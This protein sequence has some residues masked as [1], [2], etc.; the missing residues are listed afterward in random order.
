MV[1]TEGSSTVGFRSTD[2][3]DNLETEKTVDFKID[4]TPPTVTASSSPVPN[5][6]GWNKSDVVVSFSATDALSGIAS[7]D[8]P[9]TLTLEGN[10]Q[11]VVGK[12]TDKAGNQGS[13]S[14]TVSIDKTPPNTTAALDPS[15]PNGENGWYR[16][17]VTVTLNASDNLAGVAKTEYRFNGD[18]W[19]AYASPFVVSREGSN[20]LIFGSTDRADNVETERLATVK[21]DKTPPVI[22]INSPMAKDYTMAVHDD[23]DEECGEDDERDKHD[24]NDDEDNECGG[25]LTISFSA[26][27]SFS[28][29]AW[30]SGYIDGRAVSNGTTVD[31][32][33]LGLGTHTFVVWAKDNAGN[34][35][36][37]AVTFNV[38]VPCSIPDIVDLKHRF[39]DL[40]MIDNQGIVT[41]L[42][43]KLEAAQA[44]LDRGRKI[45]AKNILYAFINETTAQKDK[46]IDMEAADV[47]IAAAQCVI[48]HI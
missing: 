37:Q 3:A 22:T 18:P 28:G 40:G 29:I 41:S 33:A 30:V 38:V 42:D 45:T 17:N 1:T 32:F 23:E 27:D 15:S 47:L 48:D 16:T 13:A 20:R 43:A 34:L 44:A 25:K 2:K 46:H 24:E 7:V 9:V 26:T 10:S 14:A 12:A 4:K 5:L 31:L 19:T 35:A 21:I 11:T 6:A 39:F 36:S 8:A